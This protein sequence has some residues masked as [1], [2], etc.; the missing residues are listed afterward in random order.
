[1]TYLL[2][3]PG[4]LTQ[5]QTIYQKQSEVI[6]LSAQLT[7]LENEIATLEELNTALK[8]RL[9]VINEQILKTGSQLDNT[10]DKL[11]NAEEIYRKRLKDIYKNGRIMAVEVVLNSKDFRDF[12]VR[13]DFLGRIS[14]M[15]ARI[16][17]AI[18]DEKKSVE[19]L[20]AKLSEQKSQQLYIQ[21]RY[22]QDMSS[23]D[24][25]RKEMES[26]LAQASAEL[27]QLIRARQEEFARQR[28]LAQQNSLPPGEGVAIVECTVYPYLDETFW[29]TARMPRDFKATGDKMSG[30]ASWYGNEFNGRPTAS[31]EI[32]NE[33][34]FT[35]ADL[36]HP[37]GTYLLVRYRGK[38]IVVKINDRGPFVAGRSFDLS[39]AAA[40]TLG[41]SGVVRVDVEVISSQ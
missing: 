14:Q 16:L 25:K 17:K 10:N 37:L 7:V 40:Q 29:T 12:L 6:Q 4:V 18:N 24:K 30:L 15:D 28:L 9:Q 38:N 19:K 39:K 8:T 2:T 20:M 3:S 31:G 5:A 22:E 34:D 36:I 32:F 23:L 27:Q 35:G 11:Y 26:L 41:Y 13:L 33:N 1:M 21:R